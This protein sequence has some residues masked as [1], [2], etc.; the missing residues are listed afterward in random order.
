MSKNKLAFC[1]QTCGALYPKWTGQCTSCNE[2][3]TLVEE[4]NAPAPTSSRYQGYAGIEAAMTRMVDVKLHDDIRT[5]SGSSELD[6]VLGGGIIMGSATLIGGDP[7]IGKST[8]LLQAIA[9]LS[10]T[11]KA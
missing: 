10:Q 4:V 8:L 11:A 6:R 7:G 5:S 3:N 2:W 9:H 1:C